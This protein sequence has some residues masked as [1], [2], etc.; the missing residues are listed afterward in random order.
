MTKKSRYR[1]S[2]HYRN[3]S[4]QGGSR[5]IVSVY[6]HLF[7][8]VVLV[9]ILEIA[10]FQTGLAQ[11]LSVRMLKAPWLLIL[12]LLHLVGWLARRVTYRARSLLAQYAGLAV[13]IVAKAAILMPLLYL[14]DSQVPGVIASA[15]QFT[16]IGFLGLTGVAFS[17]R[18]D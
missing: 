18:K 5:F 9:V 11:P 2:P 15:A 7:A 3:V 8:A 13:Y 17:T 12:A 1:Y 6:G 10:L 16:L 4:Q 14:A